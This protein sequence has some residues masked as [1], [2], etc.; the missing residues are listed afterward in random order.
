MARNG[1]V[2][3]ELLCCLVLTGCTQDAAVNVDETGDTEIRLSL[4]W[5]PEAE[6]GGFFAADV[7]DFYE[8]NDLS[9]EIIPGGPNA[10]QL[11]ISELVAGRV[12]FAVSDADQV[13]MARSEGLPIVAVM[14]TM[15]DSPRCIMVHESTGIDKLQDLKNV[16]LAISESRPFALWMKHKL[17]LTDVQLVPFNGLVGE[18]IQD[19]R[20]AQQGY[21]FS[22]PWLAREQGS[23]PR[24][25]M[26]SEI[27][28]NPYAALLITTDTMVDQHPELVQAM[29]NACAS[30]WSQYLSDPK[31]SNAAI[32]EQNSDMSL[33]A[34]SFGAE[35]IAELCEPREGQ[36][37]FMM[38]GD[39]WQQLVRQIEEIGEISAGSVD[40]ASCFTQQ[41]MELVDQ[42]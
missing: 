39:R 17:P 28:F 24:A 14:A 25:L 4:N 13:V 8:Q 10:P 11:V 35:Q 40:P 41:F 12:H 42:R 6:H 18:F 34:L 38:D 7:H 36:P 29:V 22:E 16:R 20:F 5:Y 19:K 1:Q 37:Q 26:L 32:H 3:T 9:V 21:V 31:A 2:L 33:A 23:D 30:G 15:Q 27:G